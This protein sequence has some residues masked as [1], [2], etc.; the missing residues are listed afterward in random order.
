MSLASDKY[1]IG[2]LDSANLLQVIAGIHIHPYNGLLFVWFSV[3]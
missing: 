3:N 1:N 2:I